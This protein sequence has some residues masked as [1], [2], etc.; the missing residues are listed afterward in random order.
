VLG[1]ARDADVKAIQDAFRALALKYHPDRNKSPQAEER[2]KQIAEAYAILSDP[3]KRAQYDSSGFAGVAGFSPED[4]FGGINFDD[5]FGGAGFGF[6]FG[7]RLFDHFFHRRRHGPERGANV[8]I[9]LSI[10]LTRI[11]SGGEETVRY[12]RP[13]ACP[14]CHGNGARTGTQP[15]TCTICGGSGRL[16]RTQGEHKDNHQITL[17]QV[18]SCPHCHGKGRI[19]D[20][21]CP[22]CSGHGEVEQEETLSVT[23]PKGAEEGMALRV[24][25][26]GLPSSEAGGVPG[27]LY[28]VVRSLHD[29]RFVR[30][31]A[32][33]WHSVNLPVPDAVLGTTLEVPTLDGHASVT[34]PA[35]T[36]P[37]SVLR[38]QGKGLP[39]FGGNSHGDL[40]VRIQLQVPQ[41]P[42]PQENALYQQLRALAGGKS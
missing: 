40:F 6:D 11:E 21:P 33:L 39:D 14:E 36:Q 9:E 35:G 22:M 31:G 5:I 38:L 19:V 3:K 16:I 13:V 34:I 28:V 42:S 15:R 2:F 4:L 41:H 23:I 17:Q 18:S 7:G 1:I 27:D 24:P 29:P 12:H 26:H 10:P 30:D 25:G 20:Q 32:D 8:E 37:D